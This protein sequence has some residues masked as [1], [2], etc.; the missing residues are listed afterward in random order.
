MS[1]QNKSKKSKIMKEK[2]NPVNNPNLDIMDPNSYFH[3]YWISNEI[4]DAVTIINDKKDYTIVIDKID[5]D[6]KSK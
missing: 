3:K 4:T 6:T 2:N 5:D 1:K